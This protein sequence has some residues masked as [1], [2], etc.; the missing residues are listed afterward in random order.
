MSEEAGMEAGGRE[1]QRER[2]RR[3][4]G[5]EKKREA[6]SLKIAHFDSRQPESQP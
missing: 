4:E 5:G 2:E 3:G 6:V 1:R